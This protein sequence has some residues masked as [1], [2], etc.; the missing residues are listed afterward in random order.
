MALA[1]LAADLRVKPGLTR[2]LPAH[3]D[4]SQPVATVTA[5]RT[6]GSGDLAANARANCYVIVPDNCD[7][8]ATDQIVQVLLR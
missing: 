5:V 4:T 7:V 1:R 8:L 3:L 6:Q 2:F